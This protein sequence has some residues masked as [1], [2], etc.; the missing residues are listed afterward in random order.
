MANNRTSAFPTISF[1]FCTIENNREFKCPG[2]KYMQ[3]VQFSKHE[4]QQ[5][6]A[7]CIPCVPAL[8]SFQQHAYLQ[9][10]ES[11][12][13]GTLQGSSSLL[14]AFLGA[15]GGVCVWGLCVYAY[16]GFRR[17]SWFVE[18]SWFLWGIKTEWSLRRGCAS[19]V[20]EIHK[21]D[22]IPFPAQFMLRISIF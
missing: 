17:K 16:E 2:Q 9:H 15:G 20:R 5:S 10:R 22:L 18:S 11:V 21:M 19:W 8:A 1:F 4:P 7:I 6:K 12:W 3:R 13:I 14:G